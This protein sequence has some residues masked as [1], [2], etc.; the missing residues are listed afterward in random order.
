VQDIPPEGVLL[1]G[2]YGKNWLHQSVSEAQGAPFSDSAPVSYRIQ[3]SRS[4][5]TVF[6]SGTISTSVEL[7]CSRCVEQ[8]WSPIVSTFS[9]SLFPAEGFPHQP[10]RKLVAEDLDTEFY[11][12]E[13]IDLN[14]VIRNQVLL[15]IPMQPL[16]AETCQGL[17]P[18]CGANRNVTSCSCSSEE[19]GDPRL[20]ALK[21][22]LK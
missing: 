5:A 22:L 14:L 6:I 21:K 17:C 8:Y 18:V 3:L 7:S 13:E 2:E 11:T 12:G 1:E 16:C 4:G 10:E 20:A 15:N 9:F 19:P